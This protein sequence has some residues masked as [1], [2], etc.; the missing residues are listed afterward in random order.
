M[1]LET[2]C[3]RVRAVCSV[4]LYCSHVGLC[5]QTRRRLSVTEGGLPSS[6]GGGADPVVGCGSLT[7]KMHTAKVLL[8]GVLRSRAAVVS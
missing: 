2:G 5:S 4:C 7:F 8:S 3:S 6:P 1:T